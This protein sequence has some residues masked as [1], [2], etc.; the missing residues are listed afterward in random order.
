[1]REDVRS[2]IPSVNMKNKFNGSELE[3]FNFTRNKKTE[4]IDVKDYHS[5]IS[6]TRIKILK[7][8]LFRLKFDSR[9]KRETKN[10]INHFGLPICY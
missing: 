5:M 3:D 8:D 7:I 9:L 4:F 1:M 10:K 2:I 6:H